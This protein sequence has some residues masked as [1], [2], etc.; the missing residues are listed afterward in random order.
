LRPVDDY[1]K[2]VVKNKPTRIV[3]TNFFPGANL[4]L[5]AGRENADQ[6]ILTPAP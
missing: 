3:T 4:P 6:A 2:I 5:N 1:N